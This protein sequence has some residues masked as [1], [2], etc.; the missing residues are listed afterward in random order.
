[1]N[2]IKYGLAAARLSTALAL[3]LTAPVGAQSQDASGDNNSQNQTTVN[4]DASRNVN[5]NCSAIMEQNVRPDDQDANGNDQ[6]NTGV[7]V[8]GLQDDTTQNQS[9][10][11]SNAQSIAQNQSNSQSFSADCSV[12]N[13]TS[14]AAQV[15]QAQ[16]PEGGVKAG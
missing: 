2:K 1:M 16:A 10:S 6:G 14:A 4:V 15:A 13:V 9:N 8:G 12:T 5:G 7:N 11:Q 3:G